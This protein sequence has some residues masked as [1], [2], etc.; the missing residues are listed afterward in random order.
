MTQPSVLV[1]GGAGYIGAHVCKALAAKGYVPVTLDNLSTGH[2]AAVRYGPLIEADIADAAAV[3]ASLALTKPVGVMHFAAQ[4]LVAQSMV[5]PMRYYADNVGKGASF[6]STLTSEGISNVLFSSTAAVYGSPL[7]DCSLTEAH[8]TRPINPYGAT[9][10]ALE[11][12]LRW[13]A[14]TSALRWT[15]LRYFNAAGADAEG[16]IGEAH[17]PETHLVPLVIGAALGRRPPVTVFGTDYDTPDGSAIR[18]YIHVEDLAQAHVMTF[19][20][21]VGGLDA[22]L[23]N[24]GTGAGHSV[25]EVIDAADRHFGRPTPVQRADRR[26]GDPAVLVADSSSLKAVGWQPTVSSLQTILASASRW[27]DTPA[28]GSGA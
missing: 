26:A 8:P 1:A 20:R 17:A 18:D 27:H 19:E 13:T 11:E 22:Q 21:M 4:S 9:K 16:H 25:L 2:R 24:V 6:L 23:F 10:L 3:R 15:V 12:A 28:Y 7:A 14:A 5:D